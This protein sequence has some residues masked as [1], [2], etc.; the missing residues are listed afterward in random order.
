MLAAEFNVSRKTVSNI[1]AIAKKQIEQDIAIDV[2]SKLTG[3]SGSDGYK[4]YNRHSP[5]EED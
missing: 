3:N 4:G 5:Q 2:R 1:W